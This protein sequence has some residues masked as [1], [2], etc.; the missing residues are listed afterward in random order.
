MVQN[1]GKSR[2]IVSNRYIFLFFQF[3][4][5][6]KRLLGCYIRTFPAHMQILLEPDQQVCNLG[7]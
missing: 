1:Y 6:V 2:T 3:I 5:F 4:V 7:L